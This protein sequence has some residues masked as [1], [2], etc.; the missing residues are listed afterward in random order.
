MIGMISLGSREMHLLCV[1]CS[2]GKGNNVRV[3]CIGA[4]SQLHYWH[5]LGLLFHTI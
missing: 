5:P 1:L 2:T 3:L 4:E